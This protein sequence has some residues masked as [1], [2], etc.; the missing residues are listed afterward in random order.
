MKIKYTNGSVEGYRNT[1]NSLTLGKEYIVFSIEISSCRSSLTAFE[2]ESILYRIENDDQQL[3]LYPAMIF[4]ITSDK[5]PA[6]WVAQMDADG[7]LDLL[8]TDWKGSFLEDF[9]NDEPYALEVFKRVK[10]EVY[11]EELS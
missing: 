4:E 6:C 5:L 2:G 10:E 7:S 1:S 11:S 9:Y 8:P 3:L